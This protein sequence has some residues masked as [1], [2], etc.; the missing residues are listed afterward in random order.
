MV[1][2]CSNWLSDLISLMQATPD[3]WPPAAVDSASALYPAGSPP[4]MMVCPVALADRKPESWCLCTRVLGR[5]ATIKAGCLGGLAWFQ[6]SLARLVCKPCLGVGYIDGGRIA[7]GP[8]PN[9][10]GVLAG[11]SSH[12]GG[13][14]VAV[15]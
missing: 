6:P 13:S 10:S 7:R 1:Q 4:V 11:G 12:G 8:N 9:Q 14:P 3:Q 2:T 5:P 15:C